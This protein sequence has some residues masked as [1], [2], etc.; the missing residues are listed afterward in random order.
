[1]TARAAA[2]AA[3]LLMGSQAAPQSDPSWELRDWPAIRFR[4]VAKASGIDCTNRSGDP[5][6][7]RFIDGNG[8]GL[9]WLDYDGDGWLDLFVPNGSTLEAVMG[10]AK[11]DAS[12]RLYRNRGDGTCE[13]VT[14]RA[15]VKDDR[16]SFSA[17]AG[18][19]DNDGDADLY[20]CNFGANF[21][22]RNRG[23]GTFTDVA[24]E[25]GV[26]FDGVTPGAAWGD[27]DGDGDLDLYVAA[28]VK[29]DPERPWAPFARRIRGLR[30]ALG[31]IGLDGAADRLFRNE[32]D[33]RFTDVSAEAGLRTSEADYGLTVL[34]A[35]LDGDDL[36]D[37]F[38]ANDMTP[39]H[40][41][42]QLRPGRFKPSG[43]GSGL[44]LSGDG[45]SQ[46]CMGI[47]IGDLN[48]DLLPDLF[49]TNFSAQTNALYLSQGD[50]VWEDTPGPVE[51][52]RS[53]MPYVG[54]GTGFFDF[55]LDGDEDL[56]V[57]NGHVYPQFESERPRVQRYLQPPILYR[58]D[59]PLRFSDAS[60]QAGADFDVELCARG[61]AFAD[62]DDDG[63]V[64]IALFEIDRPTRLLR[65]DTGG[66][67]A[68]RGRFVRVQLL[69]TTV[70]R[71]AYGSRIVLEAGG[72]RHVRWVVGQGSFLSQNDPRAHFGLGSAEGVDRITVR[73]PG[74][75]EEVI[76]PTRDAGGGLVPIAV[77]RTLVIQE[78]RG[79]VAQLTGE[80]AAGDPEA[81]RAPQLLPR[82]RADELHAA[83][84]AAR[85]DA[86]AAPAG[87]R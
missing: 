47:A 43:S 44:L 86:P 50:G 2:C 31:P 38:V 82:R 48:D 64:D 33:G 61:S 81:R 75:R 5:E 25:A 29:F 35:D 13:D 7:S 14:E 34:M 66:G 12:D 17:V 80:P 49:V 24:A 54:W 79:I 36:L 40:F 52:A 84:K 21:L 6:K 59:G 32:G 3:T 71:D 77:D 72:R 11:N 58:R 70:N 51:R 85:A 23:D 45:D 78:G 26:Q 63:D 74:G 4:D 10:R 15:G 65:N 53:A 39:N 68:R 56:V 8:C 76:E 55:D 27:V 42:R 16:W 18:D 67:S 83:E 20:V 30:V 57:F 19:Y 22:Y 69:G 87:G 62:Y 1:M 9:T 41:Y 37:V 28:Y 60:A 73:W 46:A